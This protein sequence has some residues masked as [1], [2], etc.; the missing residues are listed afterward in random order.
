MKG[1]KFE[2]ESFF[3]KDRRTVKSKSQVPIS[4]DRSM[5]LIPADE[6]AT[7]EKN[8]NINDSWKELD[9]VGHHGI[10]VSL[11]LGARM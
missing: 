5:I 10:D 3:Q 7:E 8:L 1:Y 2:N 9:Q 6:E 4:H 11:H